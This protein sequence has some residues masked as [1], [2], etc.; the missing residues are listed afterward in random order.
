MVLQAVELVTVGAANALLSQVVGVP[1]GPIRA[2]Y[3][4]ATALAISYG[5][6]VLRYQMRTESSRSR[7]STCYRA[8]G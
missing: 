6:A 7:W 5:A 8:G 4:V 3:R 2:F 1:E